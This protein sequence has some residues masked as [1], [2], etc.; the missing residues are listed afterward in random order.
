MNFE[1]VNLIKNG[2][3]VYF[4][5]TMVSNTYFFKSIFEYIFFIA[6][7]LLV[8][9]SLLSLSLESHERGG[10]Y[11]LFAI[12]FFILFLV[13]CFSVFSSDLPL[14]STQRIVINYFPLFL[15]FLMPSGKLFNSIFILLFHCVFYFVVISVLYSIILFI[16]GGYQYMAEIGYVNSIN[17][18]FYQRQFGNA[19]FYRLSSFFGNPNQFSMWLLLG[20]F[21]GL[22]LKK[23]H[24]IQGWFFLGL[25][26]FALFLAFS[27][28]SF[29][30]CVIFLFLY[31]IIKNPRALYFVIFISVVLYIIFHLTSISLIDETNTRTSL[32]LN[33]RGVAWDLLLDSIYKK[34]LLGVGFGLLDES[35][36]NP[37]GIEISAH[38]VH[39]QF[40]S[41][42][43]L[44]G[45][46]TF[47][48]TAFFP[49]LIGIKSYFSKQFDDID[50]DILLLLA[51]WCCSL[52][53][54]QLFENT[55]FRGG[56]FTVFWL[57]I[58]LSIIRI[59]NLRLTVI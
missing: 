1:K 51:S 23:L 2:Y 49:I 13:S 15:I 52:L 25:I 58:C 26:L 56:F 21:T 41:E 37:G 3:I 14:L 42:I 44:L 22:T 43:G 54:H 29:L 30:A 9:L 17:S 38:N 35:I 39:L 6:L 47:L 32:S 31:N 16:I 5:I 57:F 36:L 19:P 59:R 33:S 48:I 55:L 20:F 8:F 4:L 27:R 53:I 24:L 45:Y 28:A 11:Y 7:F 34:P 40:L 46:L 10:R 50:R 18:I 12:L